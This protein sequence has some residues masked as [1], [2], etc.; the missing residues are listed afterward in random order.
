MVTA[1]T[2]TIILAIYPQELRE[3]KAIKKRISEQNTAVNDNFM[4]KER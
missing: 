2:V 4:Q 1:V 3:K